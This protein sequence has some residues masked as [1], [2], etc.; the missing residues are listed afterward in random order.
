MVMIIMLLFA[1]RIL[2]AGRALSCPHT[3]Y[4]LPYSA[5]CDD[6]RRLTCQLDISAN[7]VAFLV[8]LGSLRVKEGNSIQDHTNLS[9]LAITY[10][11]ESVKPH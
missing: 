3:T 7:H 11:G 10:M 9:L 2:P 1:I 4:A 8:A 6:I 5:Y